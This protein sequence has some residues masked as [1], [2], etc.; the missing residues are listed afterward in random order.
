[1]NTDSKPLPG[2]YATGLTKVYG[3]GNTEVV[4][5]KDVTLRV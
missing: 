1:M 3:H 4:A 2:V 5:L